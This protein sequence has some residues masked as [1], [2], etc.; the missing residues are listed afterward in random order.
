METAAKHDERTAEAIVGPHEPVLHTEATAQ[1]EG[2]GLFGEEGIGTAF[3]EES[4]LMLGPDRPAHPIGGI[5]DGEVDGAAALARSLDDPVSGRKP[6]DA[7]ADD[8]H[9]HGSAGPILTRSA[10][11]SMKRGWSLAAAAR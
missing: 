3:D 9:L 11:I 8:D 10:S 6:G 1:V 7:A 4:V 5:I 2:P